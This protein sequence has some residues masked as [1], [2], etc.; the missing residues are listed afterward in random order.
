MLKT[1]ALILLALW[2]VGLVAH[3]AGGIIHL[4]L[5]AAIALFIYDL[6]MGRRRSHLS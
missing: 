4:V 2:L 5:V 1:I 6:L 3:V